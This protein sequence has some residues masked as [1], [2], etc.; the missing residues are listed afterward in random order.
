MVRVVCVCVGGWE[1]MGNGV[2]CVHV[3]G[4]GAGG[5]QCIQISAIM[6]A[7]T[8]PNC[9]LERKQLHTLCVFVCMM[10]VIY[11]RHKEGGKS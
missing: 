10:Y 5:G 1:G 3:T 6:R 9:L 8:Q 4:E 11:V 7:G 2:E